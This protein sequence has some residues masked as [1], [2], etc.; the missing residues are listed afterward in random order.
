[1]IRRRLTAASSTAAERAAWGDLGIVL[2]SLTIEAVEL[3][4]A[5]PGPITHWTDFS[6][7]SDAELRTNPSAYAG[8]ARAR[9]AATLKV[10]RHVGYEL[11]LFVPRLRAAGVP[12]DHIRSIVELALERGIHEAAQWASGS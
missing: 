9:L 7:I 3:T 11:A 12:S 2:R 5:S 8:F 10:D 1:M 4:T 6:E